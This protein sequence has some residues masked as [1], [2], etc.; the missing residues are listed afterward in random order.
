MSLL[1]NVVLCLIGQMFLGQSMAGQYSRMITG[2]TSCRYGDQDCNRCVPNV[3]EALKNVKGND[4]NL[5]GFNVDTDMVTSSNHWQG[6]TRLSSGG[7]K[8]LAVTTGKHNSGGT[9]RI[10]KMASRASSGARKLG[11]NRSA[12]NRAPPR[13]DRVIS[14]WSYTSRN[15]KHGGSVQASGNIL[16]VAMDQRKK[17]SY[18]AGNI[19]FFDV[20][21]PES[22]RKVKSFTRGQKAGA[23]GLTK[24]ANGN[25]LMVVGGY[26]SSKRLD[27]Y[28][29]NSQFHYLKKTTWHRDNDRVVEA[30]YGDCWP[31]DC[32]ACIGTCGNAYQSLSLVTQCDGKVFMIGMHAKTAGGS[33]YDRADL[34]EL[35]ESGNKIKPKKVYESGDFKCGQWGGGAQCDFAAAGGIYIDP[36]GKLILY[37]VEHDNDGPKGS[38]E[39]QKSVKM[40]EFYAD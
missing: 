2:D 17:D 38:G 3:K 40:A 15:Y 8:Y 26:D 5:M 11:A 6:V 18:S 30:G 39:S 14:S 33:G 13:S 24:L 25:F 32:T 19:V 1:K 35:V 28:E 27:F 23:V 22:P 37:G 21:N 29:L 12:S 34:Y 31:K 36:S 16:A 7:G 20:S 10:V 9:V 4:G